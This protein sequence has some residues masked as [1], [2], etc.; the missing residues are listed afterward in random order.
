[1]SIRSV[2]FSSSPVSSFLQ[3]HPSSNLKPMLM[4]DTIFS[5]LHI[6][7]TIPSPLRNLRIIVLR[8][9]RW[10]RRVLDMEQQARVDEV[11]VVIGF[12]AK[13]RDSGDRL[14]AQLCL[15]L[16]EEIRECCAVGRTCCH[17]PSRT[18]FTQIGNS[19]SSACPSS[20]AVSNVTPGH[21]LSSLPTFFKHLAISSFVS[22]FETPSMKKYRI[23]CTLGLLRTQ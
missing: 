17:Q 11:V 8:R 1:M 13:D 7:R 10:R 16:H 22:S 12:W 15:V 23:F 20:V 4:H 5:S 3:L 6:N 14:V 2:E 19:P 9:R 21:S 18:T